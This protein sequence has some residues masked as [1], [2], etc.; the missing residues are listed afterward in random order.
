MALAGS[1]FLLNMPQLAGPLFSAV[2]S[3]MRL[4]ASSQRHPKPPSVHNGNLL[5]AMDNSN[6]QPG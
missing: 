6:G 3:W 1:P 5:C 2:P 4:T